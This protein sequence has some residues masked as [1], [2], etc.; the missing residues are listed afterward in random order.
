MCFFKKRLMRPRALPYTIS[1]C[2]LLAIFILPLFEFELQWNYVDWDTTI[3]PRSGSYIMEVTNR[4]SMLRVP[5]IE[6]EW[7]MAHYEV[8]S[9]LSSIYNHTLPEYNYQWYYKTV[10]DIAAIGK[11]FHINSDLGGYIA[12]LSPKSIDLQSNYSSICFISNMDSVYGSDGFS[13]NAVGVVQSIL[14]LEELSKK[15]GLLN[16]ITIVITDTKDSGSNV[17]LSLYSTPELQKCAHTVFL[18]SLGLAQTVPDV[19]HISDLNT[20]AL[21]FLRKSTDYMRVSNIILDIA[22]S[23]SLLSSL[24]VMLIKQSSIHPSFSK[25]VYAD[26]Q[27]LHFSP[28]DTYDNAQPAAVKSRYDRLID[29]GESLGKIEPSL[30]KRPSTR[31]RQSYISSM[32]TTIRIS[33]MEE[34]S[35]ILIGILCSILFLTKGNMSNKVAINEGTRKGCVLFASQIIVIIVA[36]VFLLIWFALDPFLC[37]KITYYIL[38]IIISILLIAFISLTIQLIFYSNFFT[39]D[40]AGALM[41]TFSI[42][43]GILAIICLCLGLHS[44]LQL[45]IPCF[46]FGL[47]NIPLFLRKFPY[48]LHIKWRKAVYAISLVLCALGCLIIN[49]GTACATLHITYRMISLQDLTVCIVVVFAFWNSLFPFLISLSCLKLIYF[50]EKQSTTVSSFHHLSLLVYEDSCTSDEMA[51]EKVIYRKYLKG[52]CFSFLLILVVMV[53]LSSKLPPWNNDKP[54]PIRAGITHISTVKDDYPVWNVTTGNVMIAGDSSW[55]NK[56]K[57]ILET[58]SLEDGYVIKNITNSNCY[59]HNHYMSNCLQL[60]I[61]QNGQPVEF[62]LFENGFNAS[63]ITENYEMNADPHNYTDYYKHF[64]IHIPSRSNVSTYGFPIVLIR[65]YTTNIEDTDSKVYSNKI[66][67][68]IEYNNKTK[69]INGFVVNCIINSNGTEKKDIPLHIKSRV[70]SQVI[71]RLTDV[72]RLEPYFMTV[73]MKGLGRSFMYSGLTDLSFLSHSTNYFISY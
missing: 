49:M 44:S 24:D 18:D 32:G 20:K 70:G 31:I 60:G 5:G 7:K 45:S 53:I 67:T 14:A 33:F 29:I 41:S 43:Y 42:I 65:M 62:P 37:H 68:S 35:M 38:S 72:S 4:L 57:S 39:R 12:I 13:S 16:P 21:K 26:S 22:S 19:V 23:L 28:K 50:I 17:L 51:E 52:I 27:F 64:T 66:T 55:L 10:S 56:M 30:L 73:L 63:M 9:L 34:V 25:L 46:F 6:P 3:S 15:S 11:Y 8:E 2:S 59:L 61:E 69:Y 54:I 1:L 47:T 40:Y 58:I 36:I 48:C 71:I